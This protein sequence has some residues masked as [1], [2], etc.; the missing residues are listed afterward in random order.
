MKRLLTIAL[1][2]ASSAA[3]GSPMVPY[4]NKPLGPNFGGPMVPNFDSPMIPNAAG[5]A[6]PPPS[7]TQG[8]LD[9]SG[10][11]NTIFAGH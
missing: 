6:P 9:F 5:E 7:C 2:L 11:C 4:T 8:S 3:F 10:D 1:V